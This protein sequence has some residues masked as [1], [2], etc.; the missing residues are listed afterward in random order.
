MTGGNQTPVRHSYAIG[1]DTDSPD[2]ITLALER[3]VEGVCSWQGGGCRGR[4]DVL[5]FFKQGLG[6]DDGGGLES[7]PDLGSAA[8]SSF[9]PWHM[10][11]SFLAHDR[12]LTVL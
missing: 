12:L 10:P 9:E 5:D 7:D 2:L 11:T 8:G 4:G 1:V 6:T 3:P